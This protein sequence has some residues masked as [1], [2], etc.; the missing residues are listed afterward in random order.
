MPP[1]GE[2]GESTQPSDHAADRQGHQNL[3]HRGNRNHIHSEMPVL[4]LLHPKSY[5]MSPVTNVSG[6]GI[7]SRQISIPLTE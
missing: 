2:V 3:W 1:G 5:R 6:R 4:T 7:A